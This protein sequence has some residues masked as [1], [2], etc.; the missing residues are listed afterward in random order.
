MSKDLNRTHRHKAKPLSH[1]V[2]N[3]SPK[4]RYEYDRICL[5]AVYLRIHKRKVL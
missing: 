3:I 2:P 1:M 5:N 4:R